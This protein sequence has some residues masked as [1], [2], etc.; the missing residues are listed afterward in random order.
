MTKMTDTSLQSG[1]SDQEDIYQRFLLTIGRLTGA[2][3]VSILLSVMPSTPLLVHLVNSD[4]LSSFA[5]TEAATTAI[6][7]A[8][9]QAKPAE[10]SLIQQYSIAGNG[11]L[12]RISVGETSGQELTADSLPMGVDRRKVIA[13]GGGQSVWLALRYDSEDIPAVVSELSDPGTT[14]PNTASQWLAD[15]LL[16]C[17]ST[18]SDASHYSFLLRDPTSQLPGRAE[19]QTG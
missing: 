11:T 6:T 15:T 8:L 12:L 10:Q 18:L 13:P 14:A 1:L 2:D 4:P 16:L 19:F 9:A 5:T 7:T 3:G 17:A